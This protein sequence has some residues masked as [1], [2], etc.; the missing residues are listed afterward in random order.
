[1]L[2][3][4]TVLLFYIET[5]L[6]Q[7]L[8]FDVIQLK[9]LA[10]KL[11]SRK[12]QLFPFL[13]LDWWLQCFQEEKDWWK[14]GTE[15]KE[16]LRTMTVVK[17]NPWMFVGFR[18]H[19]LSICHISVFCFNSDTS[20]FADVESYDPLSKLEFLVLGEEKPKQTK[21]LPKHTHKKPNPQQATG[22]SWLVS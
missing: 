22:G 9:R 3:T 10:V 4:K 17:K 1:M 13:I 11:G 16:L 5:S 6:L 21:K 2:L 14:V 8:K 18:D 15:I 19:L 7:K 20:Q 12:N